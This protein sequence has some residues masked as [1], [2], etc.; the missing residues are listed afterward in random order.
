VIRPH[1][2]QVERTASVQPSVKP[3]TPSPP[4]LKRPSA[5]T[6]PL[7][8]SPAPVLAKM[9]SSRL[10][11]PR[12][13][14]PYERQ[15]SSRGAPF[16]SR[17]PGEDGGKGRPD[18]L[19]RRGFSVVPHG[20]SALSEHAPTTTE[21]LQQSHKDP[22]AT[23]PRPPAPAPAP[24]PQNMPLLGRAVRNF[25]LHHTSRLYLWNIPLP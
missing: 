23:P 16:E 9:A 10:Q 21:P 5:S 3:S 20:P 12:A 24:A 11:T 25:L 8:S 14:L 15:V 1:A 6:S 13:T 2:E 19:G 4:P 18:E 22:S 7:P 17:P